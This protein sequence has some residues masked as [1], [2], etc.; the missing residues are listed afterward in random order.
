MLIDGDLVYVTVGSK[1]LFTCEVKSIAEAT[2]S[3]LASFY[4]VDF[5]Y[6]KWCEIGLNILQK[7]TFEDHRVP[8][9]IAMTSKCVLKEFNSFEEASA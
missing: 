4:L 6:P 7:I 3:Y 9:D 5:D 2:V 1:I 8:K